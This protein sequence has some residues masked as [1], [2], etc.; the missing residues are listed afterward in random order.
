MTTFCRLWYLSKVLN[1]MAIYPQNSTKNL[2]NFLQSPAFSIENGK[3]DYVKSLKTT[4]LVLFLRTFRERNI[5][6]IS[7]LRHFEWWKGLFAY[8]PPNSTT[9]TTYIRTHVYICIHNV[10][11]YIHNVY[12]YTRMYIT[13]LLN[14]IN[15]LRSMLIFLH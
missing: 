5:S 13:W 3:P 7:I 15:L 10:Y 6:N 11:I 2:K 8:F 12:I 4:F 9:C 14:K 1:F